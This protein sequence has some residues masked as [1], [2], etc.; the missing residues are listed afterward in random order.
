MRKV[1]L[2]IGL[3]LAGIAPAY[4]QL[5]FGFS[6]GG[7]SLGFTVPT[8]PRLVAVPGYPVYYAPGINGNYFF[9]DG[10]YWVFNDD[11]GNWYQSSWYNGPW[12]MVPPEAVRL[13]VLRVPVQYYRRPPAFF[14][15]WARN[16]PP[17][18]GDHWG[19]GWSDQHRGWDRWDRTKAQRAAPL[20]SYQRN[21]S[22]DRY[23]RNEEQARTNEQNYK[24][25]P[26][27]QSVRDHWQGRG[28][29]SNDARPQ[30]AERAAPQQRATPHEAAQR[31]QAAAPQRQQH[32]APQREER[33]QPRE[34]PQREERSAPA[35]DLNNRRP[36]GDSGGG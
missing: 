16:A 35:H 22:G 13:Y 30:R 5:S 31:E 28:Q 19:R 4:A 32:E 29:P 12:S 17:R 9:Y 34:A 15:G 27:D 25:Q 20:P 6:S 8:Y 7:V 23:P 3:A 11:D 33:A 36:A 2:A 26:R 14:Q 18:W 10:L 21:Y 24:Y 1:I